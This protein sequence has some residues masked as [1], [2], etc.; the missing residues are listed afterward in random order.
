VPKGFRKITATITCTKYG[1]NASAYFEIVTLIFTKQIV[2]TE[3]N[4]YTPALLPLPSLILNPPTPTLPPIPSSF[5]VK[6]VSKLIE[7][8]PG[9]PNY[10]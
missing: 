9:P 5:E 10:T 7:A 1:G 4:K 2:Y 6:R 3:W 8:S